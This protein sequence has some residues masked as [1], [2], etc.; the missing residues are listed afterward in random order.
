MIEK[1]TKCDK[2]EFV[3]P[4]S[5]QCR[6][7]ISLME[8]GNELAASFHRSVMHPDSDWSEC[9]ANVQ[10]ICNAVFTDEVKQKWADKL[11]ADAAEMATDGASIDEPVDE[12]AAPDA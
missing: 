1:I 6:Q 7:R 8:D 11:A 10:A 3:A 12:P 5:V 9:E 2:I 4:Y